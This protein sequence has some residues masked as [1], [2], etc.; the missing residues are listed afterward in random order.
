MSAAPPLVPFPLMFVVSFMAFC[1]GPA[2]AQDYPHKPVRI[3]TSAPG[4]GTDFTARLIASGL[5][6]RLRQPVIVENRSG[7]VMSG[8]TV[9]RAI[10]DGYTLLLPG[11]SFWLGPLLQ[12]MP[13][14]P[15]KE[16]AP[17]T[18]THSQPVVLVVH[19]S[20][21][22]KSVKDLIEYAKARPGELNYGSTAVGSS[23]HLAAALFS[24]MAGIEMV[25][26]PF[27]GGGG[28]ANAMLGGQVQLT[29]ATSASVVPHVKSGRLR[30]LGVA[31][32]QPTRLVPGLPTIAAS[33]V[34]GFEA[35]QRAGMFAPAGTPAAIINR[36]N[37]EVVQ[38]LNRADV[39]EKFFDAGIE[40]VGSSPQELAAGMKSEM[41]RMGKVIKDAGIRAQ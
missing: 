40:S 6:E 30:G 31:S 21:P 38:F 12:K 35:S 36:L 16:F 37:R 14:D 32:A 5:S 20:L 18:I 23:G 3:V 15:V 4:G 28:L 41:V 34:P 13:Y 2:W 8:Q 22:V 26:V 27:K 29:L 1:I 33:G 11:S 10:P 9:A 17:I 19:P 7:A 25:H 24:S 39:K